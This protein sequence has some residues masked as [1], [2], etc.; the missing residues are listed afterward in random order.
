MTTDNDRD[1]MTLDDALIAWNVL[2]P[3]MADGENTE[4]PVDWYAVAGPEGIVAYFI[5]KAAACRFR[6]VEIDRAM[7]SMTPNKGE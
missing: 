7:E 4:W 3:G 6:F 1:E 2:S 5:S